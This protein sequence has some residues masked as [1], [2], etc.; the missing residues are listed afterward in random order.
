MLEACVWLRFINRHG[1]ERKQVDLNVLSIYAAVIS[2]LS[3]HVS[4]AVARVLWRTHA[5][6]TQTPISPAYLAAMTGIQGVSS[7]EWLPISQ[8]TPGNSVL[9][10]GVMEPSLRMSHKLNQSV[11][12]PE[13]LGYGRSPP[14]T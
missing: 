1:F 11:H 13:A 4:A 12:A 6:K 9:S 14:T 5:Q 2:T 3:Y 8:S 10:L 7:S